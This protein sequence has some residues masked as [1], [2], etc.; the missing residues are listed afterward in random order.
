MPP[1]DRLEVRYGVEIVGELVPDA[2]GVLALTYAESWRAR[3]DAFPISISLPLDAAPTAGDAAHHFFANLLPEGAVR[4]AICNR[5]GISADND[6]ALLRAVGGECAGALSVAPAGTPPAPAAAADYELLDDRRLQAMVSGDR[7][8]PLLAG[9]P[10]TRLSLAGAQHKVPVALLDGRIRLPVGTAPSTHILKL[11]HRDFMHVPPNE[12]FVLALARRVGL[13]VAATT[14]VPTDPPSLLVERYDRLLT[15][16]PWPA[17]RLHQEDLC[18][19]LGLPAARKYEQEGGPTFAAAIEL[20]RRHVRTPLADVPRL[21]EWQAFNVC[22]GN[23]DGHGKNL[24]L[25][26]ADGG[27]RLAPFYDILSTRQYAT[28]DRMLAMGV[29]DGRDPDKLRRAHWESL[30]AALGMTPRIVVA[31]ADA[32][33]ERCLDALA[34]TAAELRKARGMSSILQTVPAAIIKRARRLRRAL[35]AR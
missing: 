7:T 34:N 15:D 33:A 8:I 29:A 23:S 1:S 11:P 24:S 5:L 4:E 31:L 21:I 19:A 16:D 22:A 32:V 18:Q 14:L 28:L 13:D 10:A 35:A 17:R 25:L 12:H 30:A 27:L 26:Y 6:V 9:G 3:R 2:A 20:V